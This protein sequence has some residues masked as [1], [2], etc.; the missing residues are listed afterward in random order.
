[1]Q[2]NALALQG[3]EL[4]LYRDAMALQGH[5]LTLY[6]DALAL[7]RDALTLYWDALALQ[8]IA[9]FNSLQ[10]NQM[11]YLGCCFNLSIRICTTKI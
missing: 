1:M 2:G 8:G 7:Q 5:A 4:T 3:D 6:R 9:K 11:L 10:I